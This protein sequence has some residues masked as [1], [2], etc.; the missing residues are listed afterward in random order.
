MASPIRSLGQVGIRVKDMERATRFYRDVL[1]LPF[2]WGSDG[3]SF[4]Q[5]GSLRLLLDIPEQPEFDHPSSVLYFDVADID[6]A[7][8]DLESR[9][10]TFRDRPHHIGDLGSVSVWMA[11]FEDGEGNVLALQSERPKH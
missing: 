6:R 8:A 11:F 2:I 1:G 9:G 4:F 5:C 7:A 3:L 10:V